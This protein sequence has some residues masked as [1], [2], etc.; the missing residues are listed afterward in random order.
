LK[1]LNLARNDLSR[2]V[3]VTAALPEEGKTWVAASLAAS[4]AADGH[5]VVLVDCDLH[6]PTVHRVFDG[7]RG[8]GLTDF[9]A[10]GTSLDE[11]VHQDSSS[12]ARYI[13]VGAA[14]AKE[15]WRI[16]SGR[17]RA[18]VDILREQHAFVILD[19][20]PVLAVSDAVLLSQLAEKTILVIKWGSTPPAV[21]R[22]AATQLLEVGSAE[23]AA[24]LSM[25]NTERAAKFGDPVAGIYKRLEVYYGAEGARE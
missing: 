14:R 18:L 10:G 6:R 17:M 16:T 22:H 13:P 3:L 23:V 8:P 11:I 1:L 20:A 21:A 7:P 9:F 2:V 15:A 19:S 25:V 12:G 5:N 4:L 24:L